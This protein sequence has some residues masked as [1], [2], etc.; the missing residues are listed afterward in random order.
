MSALSVLA[1]LRALRE[2]NGALYDVTSVSNRAYIKALDDVRAAILADVHP[3]DNAMI[4]RDL[5]AEA[6]EKGMTP[7][8]FMVAMFQSPLDLFLERSLDGLT[9]ASGKRLLRALRHRDYQ[10]KKDATYSNVSANSWYVDF[11]S[12]VLDK[13]RTAFVL[14]HR[15]EEHLRV[16]IRHT[17]RM[18]RS[19]MA[20][21]FSPEGGSS[22]GDVVIEIVTRLSSLGEHFDG[23][24]GVDF[25][26]ED[27]DRTSYGSVSRTIADGRLLPFYPA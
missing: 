14:A 5:L 20:V 3:E 11:G 7:A 4:A 12:A 27:D 6:V 19:S 24:V 8:T 13:T 10:Q 16:S 21:H 9:Q 23:S 26:P 25:R 22:A 15:D 18:G 1:S 17:S 2:P